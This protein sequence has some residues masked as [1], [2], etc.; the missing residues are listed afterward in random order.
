MEI[1]QTLLE[2]PDA[3]NRRAHDEVVQPPVE[4]EVAITDGLD[5]ELPAAAASPT[6]P[7]AAATKEIIIG[8]D[9]PD[10]LPVAEGD[11]AHSAVSIEADEAAEPATLEEVSEDGPSTYTAVGRA[12]L[13]D[14]AR[15]AE[16]SESVGGG[17]KRLT[18]EPE[19]TERIPDESVADSEGG[20]A[21]NPRDDQLEDVSLLSDQPAEI[22]E[23]PAAASGGDTPA[24]GP[25]PPGGSDEAPDQGEDPQLPTTAND[26]RWAA[27]HKGDVEVV[28][29][30]GQPDR[31][32]VKVYRSPRTEERHITVNTPGGLDLQVSA[33]DVVL[34]HTTDS[35]GQVSDSPRD[36]FQGN[37][38]VPKGYSVE[39]RYPDPDLTSAA[40]ILTDQRGAI[41]AANEALK[42]MDIPDTEFGR[43]NTYNRRLILASRA[44]SIVTGSRDAWE[45]I[46]SGADPYEWLTRYPLFGKPIHVLTPGGILM[47][48]RTGDRI[49]RAIMTPDLGYDAIQHLSLADLAREDKYMEL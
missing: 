43:D 41:E 21:Q 1:G 18:L 31:E 2:T 24:D 4:A 47:T 35:T 15:S 12:I 29:D 33:F 8:E 34:V 11:A 48:G 28:G 30:P 22:P 7:E 6:T 20:D 17:P 27:W 36:V 37:R 9:L 42:E 44:A 26:M 39:V 23:E 10:V 19:P 16:S 38:N 13:G 3:I 49:E 5:D 46:P 45:S 32:V 40:N 25:P 14:A